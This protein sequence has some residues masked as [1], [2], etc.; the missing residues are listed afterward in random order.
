MKYRIALL[1]CLFI[2]MMGSACAQVGRYRGSIG[3]GLFLDCQLRTQEN[4]GVYPG[5]CALGGSLVAE[6]QIDHI[7]SYRLSGDIHGL[8]PRQGYDRKAKASADF[9]INIFNALSGERQRDNVYALLG[10]GV[11][12]SVAGVDGICF[13]MQAGAG[14]SYW[15][16]K[17]FGLYAEYLLTALGSSSII[18]GALCVGGMLAL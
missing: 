12:Y 18:S 10:A 6:G 13:S 14:Y 11:A 17:N 15:L 8:F 4:S 2:M 9:K 5:V 1:S 7:W 3:L 16:T